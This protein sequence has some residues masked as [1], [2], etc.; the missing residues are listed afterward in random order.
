MASMCVKI[1]HT[2]GSQNQDDCFKNAYLMA[3]PAE[4][5]AATKVKN[6]KIYA[7][8]HRNLMVNTEN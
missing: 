4:T 7:F 3:M 5:W 1:E 8:A 6:S 2:V